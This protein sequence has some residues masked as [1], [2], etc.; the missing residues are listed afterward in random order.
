M[1]NRCNRGPAPS[2][3][4]FLGP[5]RNTAADYAAVHA[6]G[7]PLLAYLMGM[8]PQ[9]FHVRRFS[10]VAVQN[11]L[12]LQYELHVLEQRLRKAESRDGRDNEGN[13]SFCIRNF[14]RLIDSASRPGSEEM[15]IYK[16]LRLR[17]KEY[18]KSPH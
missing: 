17:I 2:T 10:V 9:T 18:G 3:S 11:I 16:E 5:P 14:H 7:I 1:A 8:A 6:K 12:L 15:A 13:E 4:P